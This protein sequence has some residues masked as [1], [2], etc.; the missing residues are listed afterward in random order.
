MNVSSPTPNKEESADAQTSSQ[1]RSE[2]PSQLVSQLASQLASQLESAQVLMRQKDFSAAIKNLTPIVKAM[3]PSN[4]KD[5]EV[6]AL[7]MMAD[8]QRFNRLPIDAYKN[9]VIAAQIHPKRSDQLQRHILAC[10]AEITEPLESPTFEKHL[11]EYFHNPSLDNSQVDQL[12]ARLLKQKFQLEND[13]ALIELSEIISDQFL[14]EATTHLVLADRA[15]ELFL[16]QLRS[17][18]FAIAIENNLPD[19]LQPMVLALAHHAERVEYAFPISDSDRVVLLGFK[20]LFEADCREE[21]DLQT[22]LGSLLLYSMYEPLNNLSF[23]NQISVSDLSQWPVASQ[24]FIKKVFVDRNSERVLADSIDRLESITRATSKV[25]MA[26]YEQN[27]YPRWEQI[28]TTHK[29]V[30]YLDLYSSVKAVTHKVKKFSKRLDCLVAGSG[31]G[32]QPLWLAANC[33]DISITALDLSIPSLCYAKRQSTELKLA[34]AL[35]FYQ[36]DILDLD[37]LDKKFDVIECSGVLH[38]MKDPEQ[39]LKTL[40]RRLRNNGLLRIGLYSRIARDK[41]GVNEARISK[42]DINLEDIRGL[43]AKHL[44]NG[45]E[46]PNLFIDFYTASECRD[47]LF[48]VQEHQFDLIQ[49]RDLLERNDLAFL[50]FSPLS[51]SVIDAFHQRFTDPSAALNLENWHQFE[52]ENPYVFKGM[53]QFHCQKRS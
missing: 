18:V 39:G 32:K 9:Y 41:I 3:D 36:G 25:V 19:A 13:D 37:S 20:T 51:R 2:L 38:H 23:F 4:A 28:F 22:Q 17:Q 6:F 15:T 12:C 16:Q 52:L 27:P 42:P 46:I 53:Y 49:I 35:K 30:S 24:P 34:D 21:A 48:H 50:G 11:I 43:R 40:L 31:T 5:E 8:A 10:L 44:E 47:L 45:S 29:K 7:M 33:R 26:Q 14:I 1:E